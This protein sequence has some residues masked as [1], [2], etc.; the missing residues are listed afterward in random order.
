M[1]VWTCR[2]A[3]LAAGTFPLTYATN[4]APVAQ[5]R[6]LIRV[7]DTRKNPTEANRGAAA[8]TGATIEEAEEVATDAAATSRTLTPAADATI[9]TGMLMSAAAMIGADLDLAT[10][11]G[12]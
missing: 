7:A 1:L 5:P 9:P 3:T 10:R 6:T 4:Q 12:I 2:V 11:T 8:A